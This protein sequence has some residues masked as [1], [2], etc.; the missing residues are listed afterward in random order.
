MNVKE[1]IKKHIASQPEPKRSEIQELHRRTLGVSPKCK[2]WFFD[3]KD[4]EGKTVSNP[5]IGY[6]CCTIEYKGGTT[7]DFF[8]IGL[9]AG[10]C[11]DRQRQER[12]CTSHRFL[13]WLQAT[14]IILYA[15]GRDSGIRRRDS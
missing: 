15:V 5:T 13:E 8:K 10:N 1:Q 2:L 9:A 6:G 14:A 12:F 11:R 4:E 3:G 7:R